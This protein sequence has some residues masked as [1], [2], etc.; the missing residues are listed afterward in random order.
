MRLSARVATWSS[1][2]SRS[3]LLDVEACPMST[4]RPTC[5]NIRRHGKHRASAANSRISRNS[6]LS[7]KIS[8]RRL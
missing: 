8:L 4:S 7:S 2:I 6:L 3:L 1:V 5:G